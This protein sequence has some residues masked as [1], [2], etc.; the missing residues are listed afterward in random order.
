[1]KIIK[2]I[3]E[4]V[5]KKEVVERVECDLCNKDVNHC[6]DSWDLNDIT[7]EANLGSLYPEADCR[8]L[9]IT[10]ICAE[11]FTDRIMPK[12]KEIGIKFREISSD[13]RYELHE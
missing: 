10:D 6:K 7:I 2:T 8:T 5:K 9:Y 4:H 13:E 11:C 3:E 1:M 12:L